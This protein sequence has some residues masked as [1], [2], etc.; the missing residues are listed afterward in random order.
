MV[1]TLQ[2]FAS[3]AAH[4]LRTPLT[5]LHTNLELLSND[6]RSAGRSNPVLE[7]AWSQV[8]RLERLTADLLD[9]SRL[10]A[11]TNE[12]SMEPVEMKGLL[13]EICEAYASSAEQK[14]ITF[15]LDLPPEET[16]LRGNKGQLCQAL[17]NLLDNALKF[18]GPGG[19]ICAGLFQDP[20]NVRIWIEDNGIG[21]PEEDLP[22]IF[23]RFHR[24]RNATSY[25]GSGLGLAIVK[26]II[27]RHGGRVEAQPMNGSTRF[28]IDLPG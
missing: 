1:K 4:E 24:A 11:G 16:W 26:A 21:I 7:Q 20:E 14:D 13:K 12:T 10:E 27:D 15:Q 18:T 22:Y 17:G 8:Q 2:N 9:L 28:I 6:V 5:A 3:D 23:S 25:P 19:V